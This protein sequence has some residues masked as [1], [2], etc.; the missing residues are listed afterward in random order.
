[1]VLSQ[2]VAGISWVER[3]AA[4]ALFA[5]PPCSTFEQALEHSQAAADLAFIPPS[6]SPLIRLPPFW[7]RAQGCLQRV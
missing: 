2:K 3:K 1:M 7:G 5:D 4:A 6:P